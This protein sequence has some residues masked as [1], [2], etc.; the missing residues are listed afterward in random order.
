[1]ENNNFKMG[2][3]DGTAIG[4]GY[5]AIAFAFGI[6]SSVAGLSPLEALF[7]SL[8]NLTSAGQLAGMPIIAA[9]GSLLELAMTQLVINS[10]YSLMSISLSQKFGRSVRW[11]DRFLIAFFNTDEIFAVALGKEAELGR[12][13]LYGLSIMP[14]VGWTSGTLIGAIAGDVLPPLVVSSL[15]VAMYAMFIAIIIPAMRESRPVLFA[16]LLSAALAA[17]FYFVPELGVVP[18]GFVIILIAVLVSSLL[19]LLA[20]VATAELGEEEVHL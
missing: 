13:Y 20:P 8:F 5:L 11:A 6:S 10:R 4:I 12:R 19:A 7:I 15:S 1:M 9:G 2:M 3:R 17:L 18:D 14:I 16:V